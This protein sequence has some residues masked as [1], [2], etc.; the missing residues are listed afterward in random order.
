MAQTSPPAANPIPD[1][2]TMTGSEKQICDM[3]SSVLELPT[4][5]VILNKRFFGCGFFGGGGYSVYSSC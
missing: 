3:W 2:V 1:I 5:H 4:E